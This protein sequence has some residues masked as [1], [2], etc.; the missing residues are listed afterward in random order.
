[1]WGGIRKDLIAEFGHDIDN[2]WFSKAEATED[3]DTSTLKLIMPN[4][5]MA[6]FINNRYG[7]ANIKNIRAFWF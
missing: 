5:F 4:K 6:D 3:R 1:M 2:S 7:Y